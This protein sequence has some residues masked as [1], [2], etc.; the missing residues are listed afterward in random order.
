MKNKN[1]NLTHLM[2]YAK[3]LK[4]EDKVRLYTEVMLLLRQ[5]LSVTMS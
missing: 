3:A 2:Q 1:K 4:I 5:Q